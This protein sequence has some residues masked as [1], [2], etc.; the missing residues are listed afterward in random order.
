VIRGSDGNVVRIVEQKDATPTEAAVKE[1]NPSVYCFQSQRLWDRLRRIR[2]NNAQ[3]EYY[4]TDVVGLAASDGETVATVPVGDHHEVLGVNSRSEL[5]ECG[6]LMRRRVLERLMLAGVAVTDPATAY[7]DVM[8]SVGQDTVIEPQTHLCG[9]TVVGEDC[10]VGP[11]TVVRDSHIGDRCTL[12]AS[13]IVGS[14]L[15]NG[16]RVGPFANLR[17]GCRVGD[18]TKIGDFVELKNAALGERVSAG[19]LT[20]IGDAEIG[21]NTNIGA[22][23][24]TCNYDGFAKHRTVVG[25]GA[26]IGSDTVLV[27]PIT[28]GDRAMT[29]AGSTLTDDVPPG[30]L[31]VARSPQSNREEWALRWRE[32]RAKREKGRG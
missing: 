22:G 14:R 24:I 5:A 23:T 12:V 19:H 28:I 3:G 30:A 17:P 25:E 9:R 32:A 15:G 20:Y 27:A 16:V 31:G 2:S 21:A 4:L 26:F 29:A 13:Q 11:M 18:Y 1:W 6:A 8:V 7:V 10:V